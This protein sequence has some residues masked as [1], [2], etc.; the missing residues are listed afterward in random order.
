MKAKFSPLRILDFKLLSSDFHFNPPEEDEVDVAA[1]F[2]QYP[3]DID[4]AIQEDNENKSIQ[5]MVKISI[6]QMDKALPGYQL[7]AEGLGVFSLDESQSLDETTRFNLK[8]YSSLN[9]LI[10]NLRNIIFQQSNLGPMGPYL[11]PP[12]DITDLHRKKAGEMDRN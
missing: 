3:V 4:F 12:I 10:N 5:L 2:A 6:N 8:Y 1:L 11:L 7:Y 9:M